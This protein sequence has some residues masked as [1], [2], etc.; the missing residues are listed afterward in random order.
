MK[1]EPTNYLPKTNE[2]I[3][4]KYPGMCWMLIRNKKIPD[5]GKSS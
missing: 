3:L 5:P 2:I 1:E 4:L